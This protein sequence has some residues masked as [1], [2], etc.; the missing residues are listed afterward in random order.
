MGRKREKMNQQ[1]IEI[2]ESDTLGGER[3]EEGKFING[4]TENIRKEENERNSSKQKLEREREEGDGGG[5]ETGEE[6]KIVN[7]GEN[8]KL[9]LSIN[10][11]RKNFYF[12]CTLYMYIC[13]QVAQ[14][15]YIKDLYVEM[16]MYTIPKQVGT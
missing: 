14:K 7:R 1:Y 5:D 10:P 6:N 3:R 15:T 13:T 16:W 2:G 12:L 9:K 8:G 11:S 4:K